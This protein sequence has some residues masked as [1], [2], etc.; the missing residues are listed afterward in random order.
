V[1]Q[2]RRPA[3]LWV[4]P[5]AVA[6]LA[7]ESAAPASAA[8]KLTVGQELVYTGTVEWKMA[9][10]G[11]PTQS[12]TGPVQ[13]SAVVTET[14]PA[15]G[16]AL[17]VMRRFQPDRKPDQPGAPPEA[18]VGT[19][20]YDTSLLATRPRPTFVGGP[21][22][23]ISPSLATPLTPQAELKTG[24]QWSRKQTLP[25]LSQTPVEV[26]AIVGAETKVGTR[27][28]LPIEKKLVASLP[29]QQPLGTA[30]LLLTDYGQTI[31]V[32]PETGVVLE[33]EIHGRV[34]FSSGQRKMNGEYRAALALSETRQLS[35]SERASRIRQA[36][37]STAS[38]RLWW[39]V[40]A[41][42]TSSGL[43]KRGSRLPPSVRSSPP[44][45]TP[46]SWSRSPRW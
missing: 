31:K 18:T 11:G 40:A 5:V 27:A 16:H 41:P 38:S 43:M 29:Y 22:A 24:Q 12:F 7:L 14:D 15:K 17:L 34:Q 23:E 28:A 37:P 9:Q 30:T 42:S 13:L 26:S 8:V 45:P 25:L 33:E 10:D 4:G 21:L 1:T 6:I 35:D 32:D 46:Q 2:I 36:G 20:R 3:P 19:V 44:A 39:P